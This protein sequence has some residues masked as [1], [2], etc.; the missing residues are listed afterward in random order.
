[1]DFSDPRQR[2]VFFDVHSCLPRQGPGD[3]DSTA[4]ALALAGPLPRRPWVLDIACGPGLQTMDLAALLPDA[5]IFGIDCHLPFL[6]ELNRRASEHAVDERVHSIAADMKSLPFPD[7]CFDLIWCEGA[8]YMMGVDNALQAWRPLLRQAGAL[9]LTEAIWLRSDPPERVHRSWAEYP[10]MRDMAGCRAL[11]RNSGYEL[12]DDFV[13][14][15][16]AWWTDYYNPMTE[17][18]RDLAAKYAGDAVA[19]SVL[20]ESQEEIDVYGNF[21]AY[22]GYAFFVMRPAT[23]SSPPTKN[24]IV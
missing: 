19:E 5:E 23:P 3:A 14:P 8:A 7:A 12:L 1:M 6:T 18:L 2:A 20:A 11:I 4:R 9:A 16:K 24:S 17:R 15:E 21:S 10:D 22:Y 13:L